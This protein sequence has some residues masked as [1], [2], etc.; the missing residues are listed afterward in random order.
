MLNPQRSIY[1]T[2]EQKMGEAWEQGYTEAEVPLVYLCAEIW[3]KHE[4]KKTGGTWGMRLASILYTYMYI[5][6]E[7]KFYST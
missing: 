4:Q 2:E 6:R 7:I 3:T 5:A 1:Q